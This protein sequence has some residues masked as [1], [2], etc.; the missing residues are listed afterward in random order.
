MTVPTGAPPARYRIG[1]DENGLGPKLGPMVVT[2]VL[3][4]IEGEGEKIAGSKPKGALSTRLGDSKQMI[5]HGDVALGEAWARALVARGHGPLGAPDIR[6][7]D[8][9]IHALSADD[10]AALRAPCPSHVEAQCWS[11]EGE[12]FL[13]PDALVEEVS[14]DLDRLAKKGVV[15]L[16]ARSVI[17]CPLR[18][19]EGKDRGENRFLLD[20][21]AMERLI[22][23]LG[24]IAGQEVLAICGKVGGFGKY[25]PSFGPLSGRLHT[26]LVEGQAKSAYHFPGLGE[27]AFVRDGDDSDLCVAMASMVGKY[28]REALM[29]RIVRHYRRSAPEL[30][31]ASGYHDPVT[32]RFVEATALLRKAQKVPDRCFSR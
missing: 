4:R 25:G 32:A 15:F 20:L 23:D 9:L 24:A 30:P 28:L 5:A 29:A 19:N 6:T 7:P 22:L 31:D 14:G 17:L 2:A 10:R 3:C 13:A 8:A 26:V 11:D 1:A 27:I 16:G 21:H 12:A 18:M